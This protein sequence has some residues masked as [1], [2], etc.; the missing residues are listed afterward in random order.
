MFPVV[1]DERTMTPKLCSA[2]LL[3]HIGTES[4]NT[5]KSTDFEFTLTDESSL[6]SSQSPISSPPFGD[7]SVFGSLLSPSTDERL[8]SISTLITQRSA[9]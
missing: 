5:D 7:P 4:I 6:T 3:E 9:L 1:L 2:E 8:C